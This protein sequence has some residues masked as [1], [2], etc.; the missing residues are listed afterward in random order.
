MAF[1]FYT[2]LYSLE[3]E[4]VFEFILPFLLIFT[5]SFA[6]LEKTKIFGKDV[7]DKPRTNINAVL[8]IILGLFIVTQFEIVQTLNNFL[9][10]VSLFLVVAVMFLILVGILGAKVESGFSG[11]LLGLTTIISLIIIYWALGPS[12]GFE[13]PYWVSNS[14]G[15]IVGFVIIVVLI[16]LVINSNKKRSTGEAFKHLPEDVGKAF[17]HLL[18]GGKK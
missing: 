9:P 3:N 17:D 4:G 14:W 8:A 5:I 11:I 16:A 7:N 6:L 13:V 1:D 10:K 12:L 2:L 18:K 15:F